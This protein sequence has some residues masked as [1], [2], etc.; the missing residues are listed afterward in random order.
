MTSYTYRFILHRDLGR[1]SINILLIIRYQHVVRRD[2][3]HLHIVSALQHLVMVLEQLVPQHC[4]L[5]AED[6]KVVPALA[7]KN[8]RLDEWFHSLLH[9]HSVPIFG[10]KMM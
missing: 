3:G 8:R 6:R 1:R 10:K 7:M 4:Q 5:H 9:A 2:Q